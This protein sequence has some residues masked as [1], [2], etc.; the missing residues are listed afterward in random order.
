LICSIKNFIFFGDILLLAISPPQL[1]Y[2]LPIDSRLHW[3]RIAHRTAA[4][5]S[6]HTG[7]TNKKKAGRK[8]CP[9]SSAMRTRDWRIHPTAAARRPR[10]RR[11]ALWARSLQWDASRSPWRMSW[12]KVHIYYTSHYP[13]IFV[14]S[15]PISLHVAMRLCLSPG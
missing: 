1:G 14:R 8:S 13:S 4:H 9:S 2:F 5:R 11:T 3:R 6:G 12:Q 7:P 15:S 10:T